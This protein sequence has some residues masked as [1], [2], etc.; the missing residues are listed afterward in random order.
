MT[1]GERFDIVVNADRA[2]SSYWI[3][4]SGLMDWNSQNVFQTA[5][6][7]YKGAAI[8][9]PDEI[10]SYETSNPNGIVCHVISVMEQFFF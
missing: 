10:V 1:S 2:V 3:R 8:T 4:F 9:E 6:L 7:R 5:I